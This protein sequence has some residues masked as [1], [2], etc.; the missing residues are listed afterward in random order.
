MEFGT[1]FIKFIEE[2][3]YDDL[4][5]IDKDG[6]IVYTAA[7]KYDLGE[8]V[9]KGELKNTPISRA[10]QKGLK[11][12]SLEDFAPYPPS[13]NQ[14]YAFLAAP[15]IVRN[16]LL[17]AVALSLSP[18]SLN[19]I[20]QKSEGMGQTGETYL[21][22]KQG[23]KV[24]FRSNVLRT[25][26]KNKLYKIGYEIS[27]SY[28]EMAIAGKSGGDVFI[29]SLGDMNIVSYAPL[30]ISELTWG[31]IS[32]IHLEEAIAPK[33][34]GENED[35]F[36]KY[37]KQYGY[38]ELYL[39]H[40]EGK[41]FYTVRR[42][43]DYNT[44]LISGKYSNSN[45]SKLFTK[46]LST[47]KFS[48]IDF[49]SYAPE[50]NKP[51]AFMAQ[52]V[53]NNEKVELIVAL[54]LPLKAINNIMQQRE[55][56]GKTGETYLVGQ[57]K[58]MR[59]DSSLD[60]DH[61]VASSFADPSKGS[62]KTEAS[63]EALAGKSGQKISMNYMG[64]SV[65]T[66]YAPVKVGDTTWALIAEI[67]E[68]EAFEAVAGLRIIV[69]II[70]ISA[71]IVIFAIA[72]WLSKGIT[73]PVTKTVQVMKELNK[74]NL[75]VRVEIN[76][77]DELGQMAQAIDAFANNLED[78]VVAAFD[79][80]A[81]GDLTFTAKGVIREGLEKT[82]YS[83]NKMLMAVQNAAQY[84]K[85][86][87]DQLSASNQLLSA[88]ASQ[89]ASSLEEIA[90]SLEEI[91][92]QTKTN[93]DS[94][95]NA[96]KLAT[97]ATEVADQGNSQMNKMVEAMTDI[98]E[99]AKNIVKIIKTIDGIASQT[100]LLSLNAAVEAA[101]AGKYGKGFAVVAEEVRNLA[102][103]T[104]K[105]AK[106]TAKLIEDSIQKVNNGTEIADKTSVSL[107]HIVLSTTQVAEL[108]NDIAVASHEQSQGISQ[109]NISLNQ[110]ENVT[111]QNVASAEES[112]DTAK[113][114]ESQANKLRQ[115]LGRF[116]INYAKKY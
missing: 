82:N 93:A 77:N 10:F 67:D 85:S 1:V 94:A 14:Y 64:N 100:N 17:G 80:L 26:E 30:N 29:D 79:R 86:G 15:V 39:I 87:T 107:K 48:I 113:E 47:H 2:Y 88:G 9:L 51:T 20:V 103:Q 43:A 104:A 13:D 62:V 36:T 92:S 49:A 68:N 21:I 55:G 37:I 42:R 81:S 74:G 99:S 96:N 71:I 11:E 38:N 97:E 114:L 115:M 75:Q 76:R 5:L 56:M 52:P 28:I 19:A 27:T 110:I 108:V 106:E 34:K 66:A 102:G 60:T 4:Y 111:Q 8:N 70:I 50:D 53:I 105:A 45:L 32:K 78:E 46:V 12:P 57:D 83:L 16:E 112:A 6:Y 69:V 18:E 59:S 89:Q 31:I 101:R 7:K 58:L 25:G 44:N 65:L 24:A 91:G 116:R 22:G 109:V 40:P 54:Q 33:L 72:F 63:L 41:I 84:I 90:S 23:N 35:Y 61:T 95:A 73:K 98:N 3:G